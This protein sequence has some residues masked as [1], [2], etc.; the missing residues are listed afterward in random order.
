M[1]YPLT[2][3]GILRLLLYCCLSTA[4][5]LF[6]FITFISSYLFFLN[7]ALP[8]HIIYK[9]I[10]E[11]LHYIVIISPYLVNVFLE[12]VF[13]FWFILPWIP[14]SCLQGVGTKFCLKLL[15]YGVKPIYFI[16]YKISNSQ[17]RQCGMSSDKFFNN[18]FMFIVSEYEDQWD[19]LFKSQ[20]TSWKIYPLQVRTHL[21]I[22]HAL[23]QNARTLPLRDLDNNS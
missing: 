23:Q 19:R 1:F 12:I 10:I 11:V 4:G 16:K 18:R 15:S 22:H 13:S 8:N 3:F 14:E 7:S 9:A 17:P 21:S 2:G 5:N 20:R 6:V